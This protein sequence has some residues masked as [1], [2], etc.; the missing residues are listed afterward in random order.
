[1]DW[2]H[3]CGRGPVWGIGIA[4]CRYAGSGRS[5]NAVHCLAARTDTVAHDCRSDAEIAVLQIVD[6]TDCMAYCSGD[7]SADVVT[8]QMTEQAVFLAFAVSVRC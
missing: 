3:G 6:T 8:P 1:M 7:Q 5:I 4:D 2:T